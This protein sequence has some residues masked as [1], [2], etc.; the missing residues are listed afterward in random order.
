MPSNKKRIKNLVGSLPLI[1]EIDYAIRRKGSPIGGFR[2]EHLRALL[3]D[4][5]KQAQDSPYIG[6]QGKRVFVFG[7]LHYWIEHTTLL[8]LAMA[9]LGHWVTLAYLPYAKWQTYV[10]K[11]QLRQQNAYG[12]YVLKQAEPLLKVVPLLT[13]RKVASL[14]EALEKAVEYTAVL[15]TQYTE[16]VEEVDLDGEL[17]HLRLERNMDAARAALAWMEK[18]RPDVVIVPNGLILEFGVI[19]QV[20]RYLDIPVV[21]YEFGE[22]RQRVW[23]STNK[24]VM[25]QDT[26]EM[27]QALKEEP[28][29]KGKFDKIKELVASRQDATLWNNF[30]RRWQDVPSEGEEIVR[31]KLG[32]DRRPIVLLAANVI[33]DSLTLDR[34]RFSESMTKWIKRTLAYFANRDD[35]Q[36]VLRTHPG[37]LNMTGPS[38]ADTVAQMM[39]EPP[40]HIHIIPPDAPINTYDLVS[41]ADL[42][43]VY[44]TTVGLEVAMSGLPVIV[45]GS[46]HYSDKGFTIDPIS[47]DDYFANLEHALSDPKKL[48]PNK[49]K[50]EDAW[51]YAYRFFF[52]YPQKYP[53]HLLHFWDDAD[54]WPLRRVL[55]EEGLETFGETFDY[56]LGEPVDWLSSGN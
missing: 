48:K 53:W 2:M 15:D 51:H 50:V 31:L 37:E 22:Q 35:V 16:Q 46:T 4:W 3:A 34:Q 33:G 41:I 52:N 6:N 43:M 18:K 42:G 44:T 36:F 25:Y 45:V 23:L 14:P 21:T 8:S 40:E 12:R 47:W 28:F 39:P 32:L 38:V 26:S 7:T 24:P 17:F 49:Q 30:Y 11:Y 9:G 13:S 19:F 54:Q 55:S 1:P 27:W 5:H 29:D 56:L 10:D 20:A